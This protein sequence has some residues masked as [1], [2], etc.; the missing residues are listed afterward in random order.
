VYA[1]HMMSRRCPLEGKSPRSE[2]EVEKRD[3]R[4]VG[5]LA[6][7]VQQFGLP[8]NL[9][10]INNHNSGECQCSRDRSV[11]VLCLCLRPLSRALLHVGIGIRQRNMTHLLGDAIMKARVW[12]I[13]AISRDNV[14]NA[15]ATPRMIVTQSHTAVGRCIRVDEL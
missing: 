12:V 8:E 1:Q 5:K 2:L 11:N 6:S 3:A 4:A 10:T 15:L 13:G 14:V 7:R 9:L